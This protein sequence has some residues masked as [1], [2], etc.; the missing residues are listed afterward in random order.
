MLAVKI[1]QLRQIFNLLTLKVDQFTGSRS[2]LVERLNQCYERLY[3][4]NELL[5]L[6]ECDT[7]KKTIQTQPMEEN[8]Q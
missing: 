4:E 1:Q 8:S 5:R 6:Y 7:E 2:V 3:A